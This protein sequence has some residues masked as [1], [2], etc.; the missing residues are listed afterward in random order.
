MKY[1]VDYNWIH[2]LKHGYFT[3]NRK[4]LTIKHTTYDNRE[5]VPIL[6][7]SNQKLKKELKTFKVII[8]K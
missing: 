1:I 6:L 8:S 3:C 7:E 4:L 2:E 5:L